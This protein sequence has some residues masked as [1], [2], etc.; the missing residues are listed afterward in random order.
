MGSLCARNLLHQRTEADFGDPQRKHLIP[1]AAG[2]PVVPEVALHTART[3]VDWYRNQP[4]LSFGGNTG[5][6]T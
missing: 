4:N 2:S 6:V 5:P 3:S 1:D